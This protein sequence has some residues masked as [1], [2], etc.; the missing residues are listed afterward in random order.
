M[1]IC[2]EFKEQLWNLPVTNM[3]KLPNVLIVDDEQGS[4]GTLE[5]ILEAMGF[6]TFCAESGYQAIELVEEE[7]IDLLLIDYKMPGLNG[8][9]TYT[10]ISAI[11]P[12]VKAIF[13]TAYYDEKA[14]QSIEDKHVLGICHKPLDISKLIALLN[15]VSS[16]TN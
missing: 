5:D 4:R 8:L 6:I 7:Q 10:R 13:V 9:E 15:G 2:I 16:T 3:N 1:L 12:D 11:N 14:L